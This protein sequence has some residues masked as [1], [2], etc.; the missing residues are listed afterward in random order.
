MKVNGIRI[1]NWFLAVTS[2]VQV[3]LLL[4]VSF[5]M[6]AL[7][8]MFQFVPYIFGMGIGWFSK[9]LSRVFFGSTVIRVDI[10]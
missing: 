6:I 8:C 7:G 3:V 10:I 5:W 4:E 9:G 1:F 2:L